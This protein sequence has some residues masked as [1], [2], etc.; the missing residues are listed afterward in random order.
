MVDRKLQARLVDRT[1]DLSEQRK[2][3]RLAFL[4][5]TVKAKQSAHSHH[6]GKKEKTGNSSTNEIFH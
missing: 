6:D 2:H 1:D 5:A 4:Y 3:V